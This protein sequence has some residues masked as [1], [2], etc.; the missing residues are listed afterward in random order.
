MLLPLASFIARH[1]KQLVARALRN[2][3][4]FQIVVTGSHIVV[5]GSHIVVVGFR[6]VVAPWYLSC[7]AA[8]GNVDG[9]DP[10]ASKAVLERV[11]LAKMGGSVLSYDTIAFHPS[12]SRQSCSMRMRSLTTVERARPATKA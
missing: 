7:S 12:L 10:V 11:G 3:A 2:A 1:L 8:D 5:A 9:T 4:A 6:I